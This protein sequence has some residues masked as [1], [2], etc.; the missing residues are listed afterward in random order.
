MNKTTLK[1]NGTKHVLLVSLLLIGVLILSGCAPAET[2]EEAT[3]EASSEAT[4]EVASEETTEATSEDTSEVQLTLEELKAYNGDNG[5]PIY[6]AHDGVIYDV[7]DLPQ[8]SSG[9]HNGIKAGTDITGVIEKAPHGVGN[10]KLGTPVGKIVE[11]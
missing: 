2:S 7:S 4:T 11:Q 8:W 10:L 6:L 3:A 5:M 9:Q 1:L